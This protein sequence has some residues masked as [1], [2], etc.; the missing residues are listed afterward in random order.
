MEGAQSM[1]PVASLPEPNR[2]LMRIQLKLKPLR[3]KR[4]FRHWQVLL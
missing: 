4:H 3:E 2:E 1:K